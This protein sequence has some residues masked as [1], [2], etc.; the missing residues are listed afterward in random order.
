MTRPWTGC[1]H[2]S[3]AQ[4]FYLLPL[5]FCLVP[6][7]HPYWLFPITDYPLAGCP[8]FSPSWRQTSMRR[9]PFCT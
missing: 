4:V 1:N 7:A 2:H 6:L 5:G 9:N 8:A 3:F